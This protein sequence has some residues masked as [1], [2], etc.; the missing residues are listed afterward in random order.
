[1]TTS[2]SAATRDPVERLAESFLQRYRRGERPSLTEYTRAHPELAE[3]IRELFPALVELEGLKAPAEEGDGRAT[4]GARSIPCQLGDYRI[5]REIGRG[6]MGVVFEAIQQSLGRRVA[7]KV[8]PPC[9]AQDRGFLERF[10]REARAAASLHHTNIVPVFGVGEDEGCHYFAMQFIRGQTLEAILDE[11]RRFHEK[12]S[13]RDERA[14]SAH[15]HSATDLARS[16]VTGR[17]AAPPACEV[18]IPTDLAGEAIESGEPSP[19]SGSPSPEADGEPRAD[20][21]AGQDNAHYHRSVARVALQVAEALEYAHGQ[22]ILHRDIK[23]ANLLMDLAGTVWV[24]DF[25]LAKPADGDDLSKSR[26]LVGTL[27]YMAPERFDG[28]SDRRSDI[29][30]LGVTLYELLTLRPAFDGVNQPRLMRQILGGAAAR[31]HALDRR[32]PRDLETICLK[33]MAREPAERY[34]SAAAL[35]DDLRRFLA[36]RTILARRSSPKSASGAGAGAIPRSP[37]CSRP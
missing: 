16:L 32:I 8:L 5:I 14:P 11:V 7:L 24:A 37:C 22:G 19:T 25:G 3:D 30:G 17:F 33:A 1:M 13:R 20:S 18:D 27:R 12:E 28:R 6:G 29:Y 26:D 34:A 31:P 36:D 15:G 9:Y 4:S 10:R 23:P 21:L 2:G 35:A